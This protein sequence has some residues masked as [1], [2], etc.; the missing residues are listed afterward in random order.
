VRNIDELIKKKQP[1]KAKTPDEINR[2]QY[3]ADL[4]R[5]KDFS[6]EA[7]RI[8]FPKPIAPRWRN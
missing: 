4:A 8:L 3:L 1:V 2:E 5:M 6:P 7:H